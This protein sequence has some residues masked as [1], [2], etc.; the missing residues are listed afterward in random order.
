MQFTEEHDALRKTVHDFVNQEMDPFIEQWEHEGIAPLHT[1][2]KKMG[3][4]GLLGIQ[5]PEAYGGAGLDYSYNLVFA[6]EIGRALLFEHQ[7]RAL[8]GPD[9]GG[10]D[11]A[12]AR[13]NFLGAFL[14]VDQQQC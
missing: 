2:F 11:I 3:N 14:H 4:L 8:D 12:V 13:G 7:Q 10:G 5:K 1:L 6:E 9:R